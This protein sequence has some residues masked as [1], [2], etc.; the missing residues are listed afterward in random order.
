MGVRET[1]SKGFGYHLEYEVLWEGGEKTW[2]AEECFA[3]DRSIIQDLV[4]RFDFTSATA[5][6]SAAGAAD[7]VNLGR[8]KTLGQQ[9]DSHIRALERQIE[10][11]KKS[12]P[13]V[14]PKQ[15]SV[16]NVLADF[17]MLSRK[18]KLTVMEKAPKFL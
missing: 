12:K 11:L 16:A 5:A 6:A 14:E 1:K 3:D 2:V 9:I 8:G 13:S 4:K 10:N 18:D 17:K 15:P 7:L